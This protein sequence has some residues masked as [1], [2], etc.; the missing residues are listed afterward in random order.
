MLRTYAEFAW[1]PRQHSMYPGAACW[2]L[3]CGRHLG[4]LQSTINAVV[5]AYLANCLVLWGGGWG[6]IW[7]A[8]GTISPATGALSCNYR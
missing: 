6:W 1:Q 3:L 8:V 4:Q 5:A 7:C 2:Q